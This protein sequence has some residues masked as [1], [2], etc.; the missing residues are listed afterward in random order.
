MKKIILITLMLCASTLA[1]DKNSAK[2]VGWFCRAE[3]KNGKFYTKNTAWC[4]SYINLAAKR[5]ILVHN[6]K[7]CPNADWSAKKWRITFQ[8]YSLINVRGRTV[9]EVI[10]EILNEQ[11]GCPMEVI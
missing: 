8:V 3:Y 7:W 4:D 1:F 5:I 11:H 10:I 6:D 9:D 2:E